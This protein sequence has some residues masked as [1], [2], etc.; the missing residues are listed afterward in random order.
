MFLYEKNKYLSIF[1]TKDLTFMFLSSFSLN[2][3]F[4]ENHGDCIFF[5]GSMWKL[6]IFWLENITL[7]LSYSTLYTQQ[8][9]FRILIHESKHVSIA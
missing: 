8:N 3:H 6:Y 1:L 2:G 4:H 5:T 9:K 7:T